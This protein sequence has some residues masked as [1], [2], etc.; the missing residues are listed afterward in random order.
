MAPLTAFLFLLL[1]TATFLLPLVLSQT[2]SPTTSPT[3]T[4][5]PSCFA[6]PG[7]YCQF[8]LTSGATGSAVCPIGT[9]CPGGLTPPQ[10][11]GCPGFCTSGLSMD[12]SL[13]VSATSWKVTTLAGNGSAWHIDGPPGVGTLCSPAAIAVHPL[14]SLVYVGDAC[15]A[16][17]AVRT[18]TPTG[19]VGTLAGGFFRAAANPCPSGDGLG[20]LATFWGI[21][22][23]VL[24]S[25]PA[26]SGN[27]FV[28]DTICHNIRS[29]TPAGAVTTIA[30]GSNVGT[31]TASGVGTAFRFNRP[32]GLAV[33]GNF[34]YVSDQTSNRVL[35]VTLSTGAVASV[36]GLATYL[37]APTGIEGAQ[38]VA[39]Y[40]NPM[41][42]A[43]DASGNL[44][45]M[46]SYNCRMRRALAGTFVSSTIVGLNGSVI[47]SSPPGADG[48]GL[49][50]RL[51]YPGPL[52]ADTSGYWFTQP[53]NQ[54]VKRI[55]LDL[56]V[57]SIAGGT[58]GTTDGIGAAAK[59]SSP[60]GIA[61]DLYGN[62]YVADGS[63]SHAVRKITCK[64]CAA[65]YFCSS[66]G[67]ATV[68]P[69]GSFCPS[70]SSAPTPCGMGTYSPVVGA[71]APCT[72]ECPSGAWCPAGTGM[73]IFCPP[74][75]YSDTTGQTEEVACTPCTAAP[76]WHCPAGS[77]TPGGVLCPAGSF[78]TGGA[79]PAMLCSCPGLCSTP[80]AATEV[81]TASPTVWSVAT[82]A[83]AGAAGSLDGTGR[84]ASFSGPRG[85]ALAP[86]GSTMVVADTQNSLLRSV[87]LNGTVATLCGTRGLFTETD[88]G[89]ST[90]A[91]L[92]YTASL[93]FNV[94][95]SS[96]P[97]S[98][99]PAIVPR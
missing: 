95:G 37:A 79:A 56:T 83:G 85:M 39:N 80:G 57:T 54:R 28:A 5:T 87:Y 14:T 82:I 65:G 97:F 94:S 70:G 59:F 51:Y 24:D 91:V 23:M 90:G 69:L 7:S 47:S 99:A 77:S 55:S 10:V 13:S 63:P 38:G 34:L 75:S 29:V 88:G 50:A 48:Q 12:T 19:T 8:L 67:T 52:F 20:S 74:G 58:S 64:A 11:C 36:L 35:R 16:Y 40:N 61:S 9:Y 21:S 66:T 6:A 27:L 31:S 62:V 43:F 2:V 60:T 17:S 1:V 71:S 22:S 46:D 73:P 92:Y 81:T 93:A 3:P 33:A 76:G 72:L 49:G 18:V 15:A 53:F 86:D 89:C 96:A 84:S 45:V 4:L 68:C 42:L 26:G 78:C 41:G 44:L 30:G 32:M 25:G 98:C